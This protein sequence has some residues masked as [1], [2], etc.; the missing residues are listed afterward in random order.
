MPDANPGSKIAPNSPLTRVPQASISDYE[1]IA[2]FTYKN[3]RETER[4]AVAA[5]GRDLNPI[6]ARYEAQWPCF[7]GAAATGVLSTWIR[8]WDTYKDGWKFTCGL[9]HIQSP[10][11]MYSLG[12]AGNMAFEAAV[13]KEQPGCEVHIFDKDNFGLEKWFPDEG[14][15]KHVTFHRAF[16][17]AKGEN[18]QADPPLRTLGGIMKEL[19]HTH[20]DILKMDV[21]GAEFDVLSGNL[22]SIGQLL[23]EVHLTTKGDSATQLQA[24]DALMNS[25]ESHGLRLFHK[26]VNA[27]YDR[28]CVELSFIQ[29]KWAPEKKNY[30]N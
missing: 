26:E 7:W 16:I 19:G 12:S 20:I 4:P 3:Q 14:V 15:R 18:A 2:E 6:I 30:Q 29:S 8:E 5:G 24:Y 13:L 10:C 17:T 1:E 9:A 25:C 22:P 28:N 21:E 27:R 11:V 23:V